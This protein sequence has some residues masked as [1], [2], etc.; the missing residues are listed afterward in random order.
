MEIEFKISPSSSEDLIIF[1]MNGLL[2]YLYSE[3]LLA[4]DALQSALKE[5]F[6]VVDKVLLQA[7]IA[8]AVIV[9]ESQEV[10]ERV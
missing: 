8:D 2:L 4:E 10:F 7:K 9:K 5:G 3:K 1:K 6:K